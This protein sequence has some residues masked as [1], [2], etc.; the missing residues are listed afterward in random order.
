M[1]L[2]IQILSGAHFFLQ[3]FNSNFSK[4]PQA[5]WTCKLLIFIFPSSSVYVRLQTYY[6]SFDWQN[7]NI[8]MFLPGTILYMKPNITSTNL[9]NGTMNNLLPINSEK[10][11]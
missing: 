2:G 1:K 9:Q 3:C 8:F 4:I 11:Y 10:C 7:I 5:F 6:H